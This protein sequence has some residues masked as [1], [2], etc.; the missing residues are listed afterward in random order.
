MQNNTIEMRFPLSPVRSDFATDAEYFDAMDRYD[1]L[2][3]D[4]E[5]YAMERYYEEKYQNQ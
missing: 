3:M 1:E 5:D 2:Y 4:A